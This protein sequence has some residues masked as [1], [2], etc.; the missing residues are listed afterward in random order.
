MGA[1]QYASGFD[2]AQAGYYSQQQTSAHHAAAARGSPVKL[3]DLALPSLGAL[4]SVAP[5]NEH[6]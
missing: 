3:V 6:E 1:H 4:G 2:S 5:S